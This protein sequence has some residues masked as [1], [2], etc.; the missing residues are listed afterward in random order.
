MLREKR[1]SGIALRARRYV[2]AEALTFHRGASRSGLFAGAEA[3]IRLRD[4]H[5]GIVG[6]GRSGV[7][8]MLRDRRRSGKRFALSVFCRS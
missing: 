4:A 6:A 1:R 8:Y 2:R 5:G 3:S 7:D